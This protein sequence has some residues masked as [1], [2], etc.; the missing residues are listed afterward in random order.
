VAAAEVIGGAAWLAGP[1]QPAR[2]KS[3]ARGATTR[4]DLGMERR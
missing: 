1:V 4:R 3:R 2:T